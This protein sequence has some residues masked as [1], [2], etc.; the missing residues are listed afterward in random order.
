MDRVA[1]LRVDP[2][3]SPDTS[4]GP[5]GR[6]LLPKA[7]VIAAG[8]GNVVASGGGNVIAVPAG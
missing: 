7:A 4:F 2:D 8:G 3:G 5:R 1:L 6:K